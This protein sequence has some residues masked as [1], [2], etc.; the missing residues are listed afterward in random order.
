M[1]SALLGGAIG[2]IRRPS[3][4]AL[5][6]V[7]VALLT[8]CMYFLFENAFLFIL[9]ISLGGSAILGADILAVPFTLLAFYPLE[10]LS[11]TLF[12][13]TMLAIN[14]W[15]LQGFAIA[16]NDEN[17]GIV[18]VVGNTV[19]STGRVLMTSFTAFAI[20]ALYI[21]FSGIYFF[22]TGFLWAIPFLPVV[23]ILIWLLV[24]LYIYLKLVFFMVISVSGKAKGSDVLKA[25]W[26]WSNGKLTGIVIFILLASIISNAI[27]GI[28]FAASDFTDEF[29]GYL[30]IM[31]F[32]ALSSAYASFAYVKYY[33]HS[34]GKA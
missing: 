22:I 19:A 1:I 7:A 18:T 30:A 8:V 26:K 34:K 28:G 5:G 2:L 23:F 10:T 32:Y 33:S 20:I 15:L 4:I 13:F 9:E 24:S 25:T 16:E 14:I 27:L 6:I 21:I 11:F 12:V 29:T 3:L 17:K 31:L